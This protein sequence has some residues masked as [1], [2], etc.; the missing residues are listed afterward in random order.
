MLLPSIASTRALRM[1]VSG[2]GLLVIFSKNGGFL[3]YVDLWSHAYRS[4]EGTFSPCQRE[5]PWKTSPYSLWN[6]SVETFA[7]TVDSIS[8]GEGQMS[9]RKTGLP[10][11]SFPS[12]SGARSE[13]HGA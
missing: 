2:A 10:L 11:L 6:I 9:R 12:G 4:P 3:M 8:C 7:R 13:T 1:S 5:S